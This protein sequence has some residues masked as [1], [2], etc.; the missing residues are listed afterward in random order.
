MQRQRYLLAIA[1]VLILSAAAN[2]QQGPALARGF[3]PDKVYDFTQMDTV[4]TM[5][6][7]LT[8]QLPLGPKFQ[9]NGGFS[10]QLSLTYNSK[11]WDYEVYAGATRAIPTRVSDAGLGWLVSLGRL[12]PGYQSPDSNV[13][14]FFPWL[15]EGEPAVQ[16]VSYTHDGSYIRERAVGSATLLETGDGL[17]RTFN[18]S[19]LLTAIS[20]AFG[21]SLG[22]DY[23]SNVAGTPCPSL[24]ASAWR[25]RDSEN[26]RVNWVCFN[27][28]RTSESYYDGQVER[29]ILAA[30]SAANGT[31]RS[32]AYVFSYMTSTIH[33]GCHSTFIPDPPTVAVPLLA[34]ITDPTG[35]TFN[36]TY[37]MDHLTACE[38]GTLASVQIP[39]GA[40]VTYDYRYSAIPSDQCGSG[41]WNSYLTGVGRRTISGPGIPT[42]TWTYDSVT[43]PTP[44]GS[45]PCEIHDMNVPRPLPAEELTATVTDPAGNVTEQFYSVW[46]IVD[47]VSP[48]GFRATEYGLPLT[49]RENSGNGGMLLSK[50]VYSPSGWA[51]NPKIPLR[52]Y[53]VTYDRDVTT[54]GALDPQCLE[55]NARVVADRVVYH[56]DGNLTSDTVRSD[57]DG[58]GHFR[59]VSVGGTVGGTATTYTGFTT[60]DPDVNPASG[61]DAGSYPSNFH[62]PTL[63]DAWFLNLPS[64]ISHTEGTSTA[65]TE[66]CYDHA[67]G[68]LRASRVRLGATRSPRDLLAIFAGELRANGTADG[69][70]ASE[71]SFGGDEAKSAPDQSLCAIAAGPPASPEYFRA[72]T[73]QGGVLATARSTGASFLSLNRT[74]DPPTGLVVADTDT[75]NHTSFITYDSAWRTQ[76]VAL[77]GLAS[78]TY[79]Y[80]LASGSSSTFVPA[81][82][83]MVSS[84]N[85][86]KEIH[87]QYDAL[88]RLWRTKRRMP[89]AN[90]WSLTQTT[91]DVLSRPLDISEAQILVVP[92]SGS[93]YDFQPT[94][95]TRFQDYD[96]FDRPQ[97]LIAPD[98]SQTA[99]EFAGD[100]TK[101]TRASVAGSSGDL[102]VAKRETYD[103]L[104]RLVGLTEGLDSPTAQT[105]AYGYD[106]GG[107]LSSVALPS[108][109]GMQTRTFTYDNR[110]LLLSEQH[111][112]LGAHGYGSV[113]FQALDSQGNLHGYD[114][115][116]H[117]HRRITGSAGG[118]FDLTIDYDSS[119]RVA[120]VRDA[121]GRS[122]RQYA[123]DDPTGATF[124]QC[125]NNRC[126]GKA[127]AAARFNY[128]DTSNDLGTVVETESYQ[129]DGP[130]GLMSRRDQTI[131]GAPTLSESFHVVVSYN[132]QGQP[133]QVSYPCRHELGSACVPSE[134]T[135]S[136][137]NS[138][139]NGYLV[140]VGSWASS[141]SYQPSGLV[142][143]VTH[144]SGS[145]AI[146]ETWTPDPSGMN[147][148]Q[149]IQAAAANG[150]EL[151][152]SGP[153][154]Y[155]HQGNIRSIGPTTFGYDYFGRLQQWSTTSGDGSSLTNSVLY[156][157]SGNIMG[158][159]RGRCGGGPLGCWNTS[160]AE[161]PLLG[162][163]NHYAAYTYDDSGGVT[164]DTSRS[165]GYDAFGLM[166]STSSEGRLLRYIYDADNE[167][168]AVVERVPGG[169]GVIRNRIWWTLRGLDSRLL[170][171]WRDDWTSGS[172]VVNWT[173]DE[174]WRADFLLASETTGGTKHYVLDHLG[175]PRFV[176]NGAGQSVG[177]QEFE[178]WGVGGTVN[179]GAL[180]F[181]AHERD[182]SLI[183]A[184]TP[185]DYM[186]A[187]F[188]HSAN[189]RFLT[190]D[191]AVQPGAPANPQQWNRYAYVANNPLRFT[192]PSGKYVCTGTV[193]QCKAFEAARQLNLRSRSQSLKDTASV[194]GDPDKENGITVTFADPGLGHGAIVEQTLVFNVTGNNAVTATTSSKVIVDPGLKGNALRGAVAHEGSHIADARAFTSSFSADGTSYNNALNITNR[195]SEVR[196][197]KITY[198]VANASNQAFK[199]DGG[200]F[201]TLMTPAQVQ[202][203]TNDI[204]KKSYAPAELGQQMF[205]QF[206]DSPSR[207]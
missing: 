55:S 78:T 183:G 140:G 59:L 113:W 62:P 107:R 12:L 172:R 91:H 108:A 165:Y 76:A 19:G 198:D 5:N 81:R 68:F 35:A 22:I 20:D 130:G 189:G 40:T 114:S 94:L 54:C 9:V 179:G 21:N 161:P 71:S 33:R 149:R 88:G 27:N 137:A 58:L 110:G 206:A 123:Y 151:W 15:H 164:A 82:I 207:P 32:A 129:Y 41:T 184:G 121:L 191:P 125:T 162:T 131:G 80:S 34:S 145:T 193:Q 201:K 86:G 150:N 45:V 63:N 190:P 185:L 170:S 25:L 66:M 73:Y 156:D 53:F 204:L 87:Y 187:R 38:S 154:A 100:R 90:T 43:S 1:T 177:T 205:K 17:T 11:V 96:P 181:T 126:N 84:S 105:T 26:R 163:T 8:L 158:T 174:I 93:E 103:R 203:V 186:H 4:N 102:S 61:I 160:F 157:A 136:V 112:E 30:P 200:L 10:Y 72:F 85:A 142:S 127:A 109:A 47:T 148:P 168:I 188:Y 3:Q 106:A 23:F 50:N 167:R 199:F 197:Y 49:R 7:N 173:E 194:Y 147:R 135:R 48:N 155:D 65:S 28:Q 92:P 146:L 119:E 31:P 118:Q 169:D 24:D 57:F 67:T 144:G 104:G 77:A 175:S 64:R 134:R 39:T 166:T 37:N 16:G 42:A 111:P 6:G 195:E 178:P 192:D 36:F 44:P 79:S 116:G 51:A 89:G 115:H 171:T 60:R 29:V 132:D 117:P 75:A 139:A 153:Y 159:G 56:D 128:F 97:L 83:E 182:S 180:Q 69:N 95:G 13:H 141:I 124:P 196:A 18:S 99:F 2:A 202:D 70:V 101:T 14:S 152:A 120:L 46:P 143:S 122:L 52:S 133:S 138:F 176:A 98:G 74:I